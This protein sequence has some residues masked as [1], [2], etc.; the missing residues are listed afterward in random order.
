MFW[1]RP[2]ERRQEVRAASAFA[3]SASG[4]GL[5]LV[6]RASWC[7]A[8]CGC[9]ARPRSR[10]PPRAGRRCRPPCASGWRFGLVRVQP[11]RGR[12]QRGGDLG[13]DGVLQHLAGALHLG[14]R[15][16]PGLQHAAAG[17]WG[18]G[19]LDDLPGALDLRRRPGAG[20]AQAA[21]RG[22]L[23]V[24][25]QR[26]HL[27]GDRLRVLCRL[28]RALPDWR[29]PPWWRAVCLRAGHGNLRV[30]RTVPSLP[31]KRYLNHHLGGAPPHRG[32]R[33]WPTPVPRSARR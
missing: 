4:N 27:C 23:G 30:L 18:D 6:G 2:G 19:L 16:G 10:R 29:W 11:L 7:W 1:G 13:G 15:P 17:G 24:V 9:A 22:G 20:L 14:C 8:R 3:C 5:V 31:A 25:G 28:A 26:L 21:A 32:R 12:G 33:P